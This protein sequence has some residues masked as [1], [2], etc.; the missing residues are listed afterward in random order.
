[1][2]EITPETLQKLSA[3]TSGQSRGSEDERLQIIG[4]T[5][6]LQ[7]PSY[8]SSP[9]TAN[10]A[11]VS[12][13]AALLNVFVNSVLRTFEVASGTGMLYSACAFQQRL[14]V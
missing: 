3:L 1:M 13:K 5:L 9:A 11:N 14:Q 6:G 10:V 8:Q 2:S 4:Q 12:T 7:Q